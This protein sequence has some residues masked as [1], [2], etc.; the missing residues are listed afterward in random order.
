MAR[1]GKIRGGLCTQTRSERACAVVEKSLSLPR[2]RVLKKKTRPYCLRLYHCRRKKGCVVAT[3]L[4][5]AVVRTRQQAFLRQ[6]GIKLF[7]QL[8]LTVLATSLSGN[9][10]RS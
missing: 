2:R 9:T 5:G 7:P 1:S 8:C 6:K 10:A 3:A 4:A